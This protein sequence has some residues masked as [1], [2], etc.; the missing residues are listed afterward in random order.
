VYHRPPPVVIVKHRAGG[1]HEVE[2]EGGEA[3]D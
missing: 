3:D 1:E 2:V